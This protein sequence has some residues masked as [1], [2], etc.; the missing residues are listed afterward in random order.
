M[1]K[2]HKGWP[3][4]RYQKPAS[5]CLQFRPELEKVDTVMKDAGQARRGQSA[6]KAGPLRSRK[7]PEHHVQWRPEGHPDWITLKVFVP[8][9]GRVS[10]GDR[11]RSFVE[12]RTELLDT[13]KFSRSCRSLP[14]GQFE[15]RIIER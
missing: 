4:L 15:L 9:R 5:K 7:N 8:R 10:A 11:A 2:V 14:A 12:D 6:A 1:A 13:V 3:L